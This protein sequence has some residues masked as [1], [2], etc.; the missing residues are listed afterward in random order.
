[1]G[2][3]GVERRL[4]CR[5]LIARFAHNL[6]LN[7]NIGEENTQST[8]EVRDMVKFLHETDP[9]R[10]HIVIHTYPNQQDKVYT[11]LLGNNS[12]LTGASLQ[13]G[14]NQVHQRTLKWL[15]ESANA[16]RPWAVANDEQGPAN[17]GVPPDPGYKG[18]NGIARTNE[19]QKGYT[20]HDIRKLTLW[21]NLMAGGAGV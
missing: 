8:E 12:L 18:H 15:T 14:W 10:H 1:R 2:K 7:W 6:A 16:H 3:L 5:E 13:N 17:L 19:T 21:G 4:Y 20:L 11:P 9:Y